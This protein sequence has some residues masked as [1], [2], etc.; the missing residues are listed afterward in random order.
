MIAYLRET[1]KPR[2]SKMGGGLARCTQHRIFPPLPFFF[3]FFP[4]RDGRKQREQLRRNTTEGPPPYQLLFLFTQSG[5][6]SG[7]DRDIKRWTGSHVREYITMPD[8]ETVELNDLSCEHSYLYM[9][10]HQIAEHKKN[11]HKKKC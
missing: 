10:I 8:F 2:T 1:S 7:A 4:N 3:F 5:K 11:K 6:L 9:Y